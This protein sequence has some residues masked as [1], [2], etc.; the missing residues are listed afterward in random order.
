MSTLNILPKP[1]LKEQVNINEEEKINKE[2][3]RERKRRERIIRNRASANASRQKKKKY[4]ESLEKMNVELIKHKEKIDKENKKLKDENANLKLQV[5]HLTQILSQMNTIYNNSKINSIE[6]FHIP[7]DLLPNNNVNSLSP[8]NNFTF[9]I[10]SPESISDISLASPLYED[11][12][13]IPSTNI[14]SIANND[15]ENNFISNL[16]SPESISDISLASPLYE[17]IHSIPLTNINTIPK[18]NDNINTLIFNIDTISPQSSVGEPAALTNENS[19]Q[20]TLFCQRITCQ[21]LQ[22]VVLIKSLIISLV[23]EITLIML[24]VIQ[25][26]T[27]LPLDNNNNK[28]CKKLYQ[29]KNYILHYIPISIQKTLLQKNQ[30]QNYHKNKC[31]SYWNFKHIYWKDKMT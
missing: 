15:N 7:N 5:Q 19:L 10:N 13:S 4:I 23:K 29:K 16:N 17:D 20:R 3:E 14:N 31:Y 2:L 28:T 6:Q 12:R 1:I 25:I 21:I 27:Y 24:Q 18:G 22:M 26:L 9:D 11:I 30:Y 8:R